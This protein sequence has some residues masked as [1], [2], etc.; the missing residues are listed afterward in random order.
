MPELPETEVILGQLRKSILGSTISDIQIKREDIIRAGI[1]TRSWYIGSRISDIFRKG[2][3]IV[4]ACTKGTMTRYIL[5]ELG[6]TG[7]FLF[8][9]STLGRGKHLHIAFKFDQSPNPTLYYWNA[10]R[11]GRVYLLDH[12]QL[13]Q[14]LQRRFGMDPFTMTP[15][16]FCLLIGKSRGRVKALLLNQHKIA[17][18]GNIYANEILHRAGIHPHAKGDRLTK[19]SLSRFYYATQSVLREAIAHGGSTIRDFCAPDGTWGRFQERHAVYQKSGAPCPR[20]CQATIRRLMRER[21][22]FFCPSCQ[23]RT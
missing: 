22:S 20:G 3:C 9:E 4:L 16:I 23:K 1:S 17:G 13:D 2:K 10:R 18:I 21:S 14:I 7:L 15:E 19:A 8:P 5:T 6:M 12:K 11:F